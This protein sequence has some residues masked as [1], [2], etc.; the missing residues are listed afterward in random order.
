MGEKTQAEYE[1]FA[2]LKRQ[3][4][5]FKEADTKK[6]TRECVPEKVGATWWKR[7]RKLCRK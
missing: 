6:L 4:S 3:R 7:I 1:S 2:E 5:E